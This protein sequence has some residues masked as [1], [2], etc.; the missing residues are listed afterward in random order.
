MDYRSIRVVNFG[1]GYISF[2]EKSDST[3]SDGPHGTHRKWH[4]NQSDIRYETSGQ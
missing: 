1:I 2:Y 3:D 4:A